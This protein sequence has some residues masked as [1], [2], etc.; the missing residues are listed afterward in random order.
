MGK[1]LSQALDVPIVD[2]DDQIE[3]AAG[4]TI[5]EI[6][7]EGGESAFREWETKC[8]Q[9]VANQPPTI[10]ALG[11]GA[12]LS[13]Q[14]RQWIGQTGT[15]VWLKAD[16]ATLVQ[17]IRSD[18]STAQRRP[19]LTTLPEHEEVERLLAERDPL[20]LQVADHSV[21]TQAK[22]IAQVADLIQTWLS[23]R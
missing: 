23:S 14:N 1:L 3:A 4:K 11:G 10:I 18:H 15:C 6:F 5:R 13:E 22:S 20:Y 2:L 8:L 16:A 12:I 7:D 19:A 9:Q 17:R 21:D